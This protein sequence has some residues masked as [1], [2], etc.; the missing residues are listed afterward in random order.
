MEPILQSLILKRYRSVPAETVLFANPTFL[1]GQNGSGKSNFVDAFAFLAEAMASPLQAVFDRRGGISAV[2]NRSAGRSY[3]PNLGLGVVLKNLN[4]DIGSARYAFE[5][6]ALKNYG[7]EVLREQC[8]LERSRGNRDWFN[9]RHGEFKSN[10]RGVEPALEPNALA[11]PLVGGDARFSAVFRFLSAMRVY[12][13]QP[14]ELR[15]MQDPDS[16]TSLRSD[17][18]NAASDRRQASFPFSDN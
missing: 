14:S 17:G 13:I 4:G 16:G 5:I 7:F 10:R 2:R 18:S 11:L 6:R 3:P 15:A 1:I 12:S 9:R 8:V